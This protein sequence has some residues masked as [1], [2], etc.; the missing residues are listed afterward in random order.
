M[1]LRPHVAREQ[2]A[3]DREE[4]EPRPL[5]T[6]WAKGDSAEDED[7]RVPVEDVVEKVPAS[8]G[9]PR[10]L[11]D[12]PVE[13]IEE[14]V[15]EDEEGPEEQRQGASEQEPDSRERSTDEGAPRER[16]GRHLREPASEGEEDLVR[17]ITV[18]I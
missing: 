5:V 10:N 3:D 9:L 11:R 18:R 6:E 12:L 4:A 2:D 15:Q 13:G 8:G 17:H 14:R 16:I 1:S 7:I